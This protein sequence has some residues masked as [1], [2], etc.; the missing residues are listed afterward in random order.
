MCVCNVVMTKM[1]KLILCISGQKQG[2]VFSGNSPNDEEKSREPSFE[3]STEEA[4]G[5]E[6]LDRS[7]VLAP[8]RF[9][10]FNLDS[11]CA[12]RSIQLQVQDLGLGYDSEETVLFKYCYGTCPYTRSNYDL[13]LTNLLLNGVLRQPASEDIWQKS[14]C[15]RPTRLEDA[16]FLDN[17]QHWHRLEKLSA[18]GCGCI[19]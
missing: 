11:H 19:G 15:C 4:F 7:M 1:M 13:T 12:L 9:R 5:D 17:S 18:A 6:P 16:A 10:R 3:G 8:V 14:R 2:N